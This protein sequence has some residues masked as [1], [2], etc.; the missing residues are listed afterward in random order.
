MG[1]KENFTTTTDVYSHNSLAGQQLWPGGQTHRKQRTT[2]TAV[3]FTQQL[4][5]PVPGQ[6]HRNRERMCRHSKPIGDG[7]SLF[8]MCSNHIFIY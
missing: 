5:M 7:S 4:G 2:T 1:C 8:L 6:T 3:Y